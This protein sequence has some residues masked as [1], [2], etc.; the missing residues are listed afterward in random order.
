MGP[1]PPPPPEAVSVRSDDSDAPR[2]CLF[3]AE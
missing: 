1:G 3:G 2:G